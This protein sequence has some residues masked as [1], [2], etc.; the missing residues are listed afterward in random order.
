MDDQKNQASLAEKLDE[1]AALEKKHNLLGVRFATKKDAQVP[2]VEAANYVLHVINRS[3]DLL[4]R[5]DDIPR[6]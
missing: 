5:K 2:G 3:V 1:I 6:G 4:S